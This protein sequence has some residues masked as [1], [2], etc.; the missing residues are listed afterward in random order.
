MSCHKNLWRTEGNDI[1]DSRP[2]ASVKTVL[3]MQH[4]SAEMS[5]PSSLISAK[6][7]RLH[8]KAQGRVREYE[9][10][11]LRCRVHVVLFCLAMLSSTALGQIQ[12]DAGK[13]VRVSG[14]LIELS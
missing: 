6:R 14:R 10:M 11:K 8:E 13:T 7:M 4:R 9:A 2:S 3:Q 5:F 12:K 1:L